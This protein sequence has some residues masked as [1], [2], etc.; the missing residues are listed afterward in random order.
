M[1]SG[2]GQLEFSPR[3]PPGLVG[4]SFRLRYRGRIL[5]VEIRGREARY[6]L[7]SGD[8]ITITHHGEQVP[9]EKETVTTQVPPIEPQPSPSQPPGREPQSCRSRSL[10]V[11]V[12]SPN[13][14]G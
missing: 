6:S 3:L 2:F 14:H 7:L 9:L 1:R 8:P 11:P 13:V 4:I 10:S 12:F 5:P